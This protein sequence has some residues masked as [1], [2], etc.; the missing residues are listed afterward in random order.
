MTEAEREG[1]FR[2]VMTESRGIILNTVQAFAT[3]IEDQDD[4]FQE[5]ALHIWA[6][7]PS[8]RGDAKV[9]T[10]A[11]RVALNTALNWRRGER[12]R[13]QRGD[14]VPH[15]EQASDCPASH[16][17]QTENQ[18]MLAWLHRQVHLLRP[19]DRA[20]MLLHLEGQTYREI[21]DVVG[22]SESNV[23]VKLSRIKA[24]FGDLA[25]REFNGL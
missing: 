11:Y 19:V 3:G 25:R 13:R 2:R 1:V 5:I 17:A 4:L 18:E 8:F 16:A 21:A 14:Y 7:T 15:V 22:M 24:R 23:G 20:L 12:K 6:S 10:W 9:T